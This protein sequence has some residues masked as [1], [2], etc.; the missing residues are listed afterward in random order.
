VSALRAYPRVVMFRT[1]APAPGAT[2]SPLAAATLRLVEEGVTPAGLVERFGR[3]GATL[4]VE[5]AGLLL[6][7]LARLG[8]V[9]VARN[10]G[11]GRVHVLTS[12]GHQIRDSGFGDGAGIA[13]QLAELE[14]L[15]TD[16]LSTIAHEL[17]TPLTAVRTC[18]GVLRDPETSPTDAE[19]ETLLATIERN[20]DR[21]QRVVG[22]ILEIA[23]FRT[24]EVV[25]Q[26]RRFDALELTRGAIASVAPLAGQRHQEITLRPPAIAIRVFGDHR[27]LEQALVNLLS[28]AVK[29]GP[30]GGRIVV[31]VGAADDLVTWS[32][33]DDGPGISPEDQVHL[34]E[35]FFV[36][37]NDREG[38]PRGVGL[39]LPTAL[40][41]AQAHGGR[42]DVE[43]AP[44]E[45]SLFTLVVPRE[46]PHD[47]D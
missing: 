29:Y 31:R 33:R 14:R 38:G 7:E 43:S 47:V 42:I 13:D 17:R 39:G 1:D 8:L 41:I 6:A 15:R 36:G 26:L 3:T 34:F 37:P 44:G 19:L 40:A 20:A 9:R 22:D 45:G 27:R 23:R 35:R 28:N 46:G 12:L 32:V 5:Q 25:L 18:V 16:L 24:G 30:A 10:N 4:D 11:D 21:M 2:P